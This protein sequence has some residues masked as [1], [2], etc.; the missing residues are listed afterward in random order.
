LGA[1]APVSLAPREVAPGIY[2]AR[3]DAGR[4]RVRLEVRALG[5]VWHAEQD[6]P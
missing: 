2:A 3:L 4:W 6:A 5:H 1:R